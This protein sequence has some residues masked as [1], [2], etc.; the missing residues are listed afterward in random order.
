[1]SL[2]NLLPIL[3]SETTHNPQ[4]NE[5]RR[6][7]NN[8]PKSVRDKFYRVAE[9]D[10]NQARKIAQQRYLELGKMLRAMVKEYYASI[11]QERVNSIIIRVIDR[12][13]SQASIF[14]DMEYSNVWYT[15]SYDIIEL[16]KDMGF[17]DRS[18]PHWREEP[19]FYNRYLEITAS[20]LV[21]ILLA[22]AE[23]ALLDEY[24]SGANIDKWVEY[25]F[26]EALKSR[27]RF[28]RDRRKQNEALRISPQMFGMNLDDWEL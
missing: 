4:L 9:L 26:R 5:A 13:A 11:E 2:L 19:N 21:Q 16:A 7:H 12:L 24:Q 27:K 3:P 28:A 1:M 18:L 15:D 23:E 6:R 22:F 25:I 10:L 17:G 20:D 14:P 8:L